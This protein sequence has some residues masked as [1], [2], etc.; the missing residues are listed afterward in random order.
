MSRKRATKP[1]VTDAPPAP[2][3]P[4]QVLPEVREIIVKELTII[5]HPRRKW[6]LKNLVAHRLKEAFEAVAGTAIMTSYPDVAELHVAMHLALSQTQLEIGLLRQDLDEALR[7]LT[8]RGLTQQ[9]GPA[10]AD[11]EPLDTENDE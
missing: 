5:L 10:P 11:D 4:R 9:P 2:P 6:S 3:P 1:E 7:R 8:G